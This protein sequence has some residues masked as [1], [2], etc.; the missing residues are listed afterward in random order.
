MDNAQI[1]QET[2]SLLAAEFGPSLNDA[3]K[4]AT[5]GELELDRGILTDI[6]AHVSVS[7]IAHYIVELTPVVLKKWSEVQDELAALQAAKQSVGRSSIPADVFEKVVRTIIKV[8][9]Q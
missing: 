1:A 8:I 5:R 6:A 4:Q 7:L 9:R 3:T 2:A